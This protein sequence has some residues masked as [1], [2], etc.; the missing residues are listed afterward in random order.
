MAEKP[1]PR[2]LPDPPFARDTGQAMSEENV[3]VVRR[4]HVVLN[5][6][7]EAAVLDLL[8]PEVVWVTNVAGPDTRTFLGHSGFRE[9]VAL[10]AN[11]LDD[12][13]LDAD[14]YID[15]GARVVTCGQMRA[16]GRSSG[17]EVETPRSWLWSVRE[18]RIVAHQ[19]FDTRSDALEAA[20][21]A[22][23]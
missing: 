19:T 9:L 10:F 6:R 14:E 23:R 2:S 1:A 3:E 16:R 12:V 7:D 4:F 8:D 17:V 22:E 11:T 18:G 15:A 13:R 5:A 21:L 20:G